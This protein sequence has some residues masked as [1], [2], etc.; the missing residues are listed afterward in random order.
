MHGIERPIRIEGAGERV[1][2]ET[3]SVIV[4]DEDHGRKRA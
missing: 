2:I 3:T 4:V 1:S